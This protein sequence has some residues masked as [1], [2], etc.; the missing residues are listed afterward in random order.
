MP[1]LVGASGEKKGL[2]IVARHADLWQVWA[3]MDGV[4]EFRRL[5]GVLRG[6]CEAVGRDPGTIRRIVGAKLIL[7][8][9][10]TDAD[11]EFARQLMVQP[12]RGEVLDYIANI[13]LWRTTP[14]AC[15]DAIGA[16]QAAGAVGS[17]AQF[18]PPYDHETIERLATE[19]APQLG[20]VARSAPATTRRSD[21]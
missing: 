17:I 16:L 8:D 18:Y 10:R 15:V 3:P 12:W 6:H 20:W 4:D 9:H 14:S 5:D 2:R 7:R 1:V 21:A 19:V 13:G 11:A